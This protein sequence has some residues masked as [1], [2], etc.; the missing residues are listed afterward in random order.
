MRVLV[1]GGAGFIGTHTCLALIAKGYEIIVLE[2]FVNSHE[3]SLKRISKIINF[4]KDTKI[5]IFK[6]DIRDK[7]MLE[8]LFLK[9]KKDNKPITAVLHFAGL[10]CVEESIKNP[11]LYWDVNFNGSLN[12]LRTMDKYDCK[13][14]V[15]SS[16]AT[17]YSISRNKYLKE[18]S[19]IGPNNP[20]GETKLAVEK[21]LQSLHSYNEKEWRIVNLRYFNPIGAHP[22]GLIGESALGVP[23]NIFP[24]ITQVASGILDKVYIFGND[25]P[26][27][28]GTG[29]RDYIHVMDIAEGH[30]AALDLLLKSGPKL[31]NIN[32]GTGTGTS[33]LEL[34]N[35]FQ[36][37]NK[38]NIPYEIKNR[39]KG[40]LPSVIADN[41]LAIEY[42][43]WRPKR[44]LSEMC[45]DGWKWQNLNPRGYLD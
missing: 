44:T 21:L 1:T 20:Y 37:I 40:D 11:I 39:R 3:N 19:D 14:I 42:L 16:S 23:N 26:T 10:K 6:A 5:E 34:I 13:I 17:I 7:E 18:N 43:N 9:S 27:K 30:V 32:L 4:K 28:D 12:L 29:I 31:L 33:V 24:Y 41:S 45:A 36:N 38:V 8:K 2:S 15:F 35:I 22:S 25:W